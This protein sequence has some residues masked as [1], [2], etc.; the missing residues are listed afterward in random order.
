VYSGFDGLLPLLYALG[1]SILNRI[2][3]SATSAGGTV[4]L[5]LSLV[6]SLGISLLLREEAYPITNQASRSHVLRFS[7]LYLYVF[8]QRR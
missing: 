4:Y 2:I 7:M 8:F 3:A 5:R 6:H 1:L